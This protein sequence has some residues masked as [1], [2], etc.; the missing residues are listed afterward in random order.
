M[1]NYAPTIQTS[2]FLGVGQSQVVEIKIDLR[3]GRLIFR[4]AGC[5]DPLQELRMNT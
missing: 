5:K 1:K 4:I 2:L 3:I